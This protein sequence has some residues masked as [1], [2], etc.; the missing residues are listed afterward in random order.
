M[1]LGILKSQFQNELK[2]L[3]SLQ[4]IDSL[5]FMLSHSFLNLS[6]A[7]TILSKDKV[8]SDNQKLQF[9]GVLN[10]LKLSE[11][12]Q[13]ILGVCEFNDLTFKVTPATLI[14]RPETEELVAWVLKNSTP[15]ASILDIGTGSGCIA[16]SLAKHLESSKVFALD[17]SAAALEVA[18][19]N[20]ELNQVQV[21]FFLHDILSEEP[22]TGTFDCI[23]SNP[24][25]V[26]DLE[27]EKMHTNVLDYEPHSALFVSDTD[28]LLF[29]RK[30]LQKAKQTLNN[31]GFIFFEINE[32]LSNDLVKLL[33][34]EGFSQVELKKDF[35]EKDRMIKAVWHE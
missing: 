11:P 9:E 25:Y 8:L 26:R 29:Y 18:K 31:Q 16:I 21:N 13:Y 24:P 30:I 20:A 19:E 2:E 35:F 32:Y 7:E 33:E 14:P 34:K 5:F 15:Y 22:L 23:V 3:Y 6:K 27:K 28:P 4:E 1:N 12:I 17:V 10:K